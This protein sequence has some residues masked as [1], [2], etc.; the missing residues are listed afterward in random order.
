MHRHHP[1]PV[2]GR[3]AGGE[4]RAP[5]HA[6]GAR[7][8]RVLPLAA[9][10]AVRPRASHLAEPRSVR[11]VGGPRLDAALLD[12]APHGRAGREPEVRDARRSVGD[13]RRHQAFPAARQPLPRASGVSLDL[14]GRDDHRAPRAGPGHERRHGHRREVAR[15]HLQP[16]RVRP[17]RLRRL[18]L[19]RRR[20]H[21]GG[22]LRRGRLAGRPP[23]PRQPLLGLRQQSHHD[24]RQHRARLQRGRGDA[25]HRVRLERHP[26]GRR[27][28]PGD[29]RARVPDVQADPRPPHPRHRGQPHRLRRAAQAGHE[30]GA[31]RTA[32]R[33]GDPPHQTELW[34]AGGGEVPRARRRPRALR[35]RDRRPR[36][37][38]A[39]RLVGDVRAVSSSVPG[40][41][42]ERLPHDAPRAARGLG[43][44]VAG[45][46]R[47]REGR[48]HARCLRQG[49]ERGRAQRAVGPRRFGRSGT[50]LQ[51]P[52]RLRRGRRLQRG[53]AGVAAT[54]TS[55]SA[56]MPWARS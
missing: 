29:A 12:A 49:P 4:L 28:R 36:R 6:D 1:Y 14:G 45:V 52:S 3:G 42:R 44:G 30:R 18:R 31:R 47:R 16:A 15:E 37:R 32:R 11:A 53:G 54:C 50:F 51:D 21:D 22:D 27:Q 26:R 41:G 8:G 24:R 33:R 39:P 7:P 56:S 17:L 23:G 25:L 13:A 9:G 5:G 43:P 20:L 46:P 10:P 34:L 48:G 35:G 40:A 19:V 2:H 55:A 38:A